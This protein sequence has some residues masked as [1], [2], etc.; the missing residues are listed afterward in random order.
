MEGEPQHAHLG[1]AREKEW[2]LSRY[3]KGKEETNLSTRIHRGER[4]KRLFKIAEFLQSPPTR[5]RRWHFLTTPRDKAY[6][7]LN[8]ILHWSRLTDRS[9][10]SVAHEPPS[11]SRC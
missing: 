10:V 4:Q 2:L 8:K 5:G 11:T 1:S 6:R 3:L 7:H 9:A